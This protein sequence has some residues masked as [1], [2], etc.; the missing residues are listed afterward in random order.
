LDPI[1]MFKLDSFD[2]LIVYVAAGLAFQVY[3]EVAVA[4]EDD[5]RVLARHTQVKQVEIAIGVTS[6]R[7]RRL[8]QRNY[9]DA[10]EI[11]SDL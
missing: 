4:L 1:Q 10:A 7:K 9:S 5:L 11:V 2:S 8:V 3:E 6:D